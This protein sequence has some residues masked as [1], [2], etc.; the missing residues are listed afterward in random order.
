MIDLLESLPRMGELV[1]TAPRGGSLSDATLGKVMRSIHED[2]TANGG[3]GYVDAQTGEAAVPHGLRSTFRVWVAERTDF[4]GEMA[5]I[6]LAHKVG[7]KV[8]QAYDRSD[9]LEKRRAMMAEWGEFLG[10]RK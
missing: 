1:F 6:A 9:L 2:D 7:S 3:A 10:G 8:R 4:D 5:E